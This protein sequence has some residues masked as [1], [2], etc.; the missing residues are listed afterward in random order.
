MEKSMMPMMPAPG[1]WLKRVIGNFTAVA[2]IVAAAFVLGRLDQWA[3][4]PTPDVAAESGE[5]GGSGLIIRSEVLC[6]WLPRTLIDIGLCELNASLTPTHHELKV[7]LESR[8]QENLWYAV[9]VRGH[10]V[11]G[12]VGDITFVR[13]PCREPEHLQDLFDILA[14]LAANP[15]PDLTEGEFGAIVHIVEANMSEQEF[16]EAARERHVR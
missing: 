2:M 8:R 13:H 1:S 12:G 7:T 14:A 11:N 3:T 15:R 5:L 16:I 6:F 9:T 10:Q 4:A